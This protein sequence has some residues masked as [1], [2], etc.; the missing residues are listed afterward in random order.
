MITL[1]KVGVEWVEGI[2]DEGQEVRYVH[3]D[4][5]EVH[6]TYFHPAVPAP[7]RII[8]KRAFMQRFTR[9]ERISIRN[10]A[11]DII[12]DV[13]E[14]LKLASF[15]DLDTPDVAQ[16]LSYMASI[17][18]IEEHRIPT[19]LIDGLDTEKL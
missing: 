9:D 5:H 1:I 3:E 18:I 2:P 6:T 13:Y 19:L 14:D 16:A 11:D 17:N 15:I 8:T 12:I 4:G 10:S 7:L